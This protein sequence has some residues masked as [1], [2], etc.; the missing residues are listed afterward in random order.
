MIRSIYYYHNRT[1][2]TRYRARLRALL[3]R[4]RR[5]VQELQQVCDDTRLA[6]HWEE[7]RRERR[8]RRKYEKRQQRFERH[9][10]SSG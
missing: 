4:E 3:N 6:I 2:D 1:I 7:Q 9:F 8:E 10:V 5:K